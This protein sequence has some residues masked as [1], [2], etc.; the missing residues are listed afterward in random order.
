M[1]EENDQENNSTVA[2]LS[3]LKEIYEQSY[4]FAYLLDLGIIYYTVY[5]IISLLAIVILPL[6]SI[7]LLDII[8]RNKDLQ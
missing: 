8:K 2:P 4:L 5:M 1:T 6:A 3:R 7:L